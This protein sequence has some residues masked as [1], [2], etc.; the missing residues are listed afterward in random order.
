MTAQRF[1]VKLHSKTLSNF[2]FFFNTGH[3][4]QKIR[5]C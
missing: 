1:T 5:E 2:S 4:T 3:T